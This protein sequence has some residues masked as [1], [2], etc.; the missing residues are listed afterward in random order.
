MTA[1][2]CARLLFTILLE[3][4]CKLKLILIPNWNDSDECDNEDGTEVVICE[5]R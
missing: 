4:Y 2:Q 5:P 1:V 3:S